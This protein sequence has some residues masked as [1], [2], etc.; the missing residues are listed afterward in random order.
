MSEPHARAAPP[1][2]GGR[3]PAPPATGDP[4]RRPDPSDAGPPIV[5]RIAGVPLGDLGNA[6][7]DARLLTAVL[8]RRGSLAQWLVGC[9]VGRSTVEAAFPGCGWPLDPPLSWIY[10]PPEPSDPEATMTVDLDEL[11]LGELGD[12]DAD[13]SLLWAIALRQ[14]RVGRW[15][16]E[17][18]VDADAVEVAFPGSGWA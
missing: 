2:G 9:G 16:A 8:L 18:G 10:Q 6:R 3:P 1:A 11:R 5:V 15:L 14:G 7:V 13:A 4:G 17:H 12:R